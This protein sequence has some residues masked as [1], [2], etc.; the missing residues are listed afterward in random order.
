MREKI[1]LRTG[2]MSVAHNDALIETGSIG[3]CVVVALYDDKVRVG[4]MAHSM[5]PTR[6]K[7]LDSSDKSF[8]FRYVDEA[9]QG[10]LQEVEKA[11]GKKN[12]ITARLVGGAKMFKHL[13]GDDEGIGF[14]NIAKARE[15]LEGMKIDILSEDV[16]GS[17][18]RLAVFDLVTGVVEVD[19]KM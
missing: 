5:L 18:G 3:S 7:K 12:N 11:G 14:Q 10:L 17:S 19:T 2:Q 9:I 13:T 6:R 16:G 4:G 15:V 8:S 1:T